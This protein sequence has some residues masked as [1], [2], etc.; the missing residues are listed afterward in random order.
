MYER[1]V[2]I[3]FF[4]LICISLVSAQKVSQNGI[5]IM[6]DKDVYFCEPIFKGDSC[7]IRAK[8]T[9]TNS[10]QNQY[11]IR[12]YT[13][14]S[15][16]DIKKTKFLLHRKQGIIQS[17]PKRK[18][19]III[20]KKRK[21][22]FLDDNSFDSVPLLQKDKFTMTVEFWANTSGKFN[23]SIDLYNPST[24]QFIGSVVL[25]PFYNVTT[26]ATTP[27]YQLIDGVA[28]NYS[29]DKFNQKIDITS[30][31]SDNNA[32]TK[33]FSQYAD[34]P[35]EKKY[36]VEGW[37]FNELEPQD[38]L[39]SFTGNNDGFIL[40]NVSSIV[41][42][43]YYGHALREDGAYLV[44]DRDWFTMTPH[45]TICIKF[46]Q[47]P[48]SSYNYFVDN[49]PT[50]QTGYAFYMTSTGIVRCYIENS[51]TSVS[52]QSS[53]SYD[54]GN[55]HIACCMQDGSN[56]SLWV[57]GSLVDTGGYVGFVNSST[58][59]FIGDSND[60]DGRFGGDF[61]Q[62]GF[63][64][65]S[66]NAS[67]IASFGNYSIAD[68]TKAITI[69]P[70]FNYTMTPSNAT[71]YLKIT[72]EVKDLSTIRVMAYK[73]MTD[74]NSSAYITSNIQSGV[75]YFKLNDIIYDGYNLPFRVWSLLA[76]TDVAI[77]EIQL[78]ETGDDNTSP[79]IHN[80]WLNT[81]NIS[82]GGSVRMA[83]NIT[84][85]I[86]IYKTFFT[87]NE[88]WNG[89][90][91]YEA[92]KN[93]DVWYVDLTYYDHYNETQTVTFYFVNTSDLAGNTANATLNLT[94]GYECIQSCVENWTANYSSCQINDSQFKTYYDA[95]NCGTFDNLPSD[96]GTWVACDY[97][98]ENIV[99]NET[100]CY[101][102]GGSYYKNVSY[103]D[104]NYASCCQV[105]NL[106]S[107]CSILFYP[108]NTTTVQ[109]CLFFN[110]TMT[111]DVNT[112]A[113]YGFFN[114]K[115]KWICYPQGNISQKCVSYVKDV[116][117]G[118]VQVNPEYKQ[119]PTTFVSFSS[120]ETEPRTFFVAENGLVTVYFTKDNLIF[121]GREYIFGVK[122]SDGNKTVI[123]EQLM[124]PEYE[125]I[126]KPIGW[127]LF[128]RNNASMVFPSFI[129][130]LLIFLGLAVVVLLFSIFIK[131]QLR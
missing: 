24:D 99:T 51:A 10:N 95:N 76:R 90:R 109:S 70:F 83:C 62:L 84:D 116:N 122:C 54:D 48:D 4:V 55:W 30:G 88:S 79:V 37:S 69:D 41:V 22:H 119:K 57:D 115:I 117:G 61:A 34:S 46:R 107:D 43:D 27:S 28:M 58:D 130:L 75:S 65:T 17:L 126:V 125:N 129:M 104:I 86:G 63:F 29:Q 14:F 92:N 53:S 110:N 124:T 23:Y 13:S 16:H 66:L 113:E 71:Y 52:L 74:V 45:Y 44:H 94:F 85:N 2:F 101:Y 1:G 64:N 89:T 123:Y 131:K 108:Y 111:C 49:H 21:Q 25:D 47:P 68:F 112:F 3:A 120:D 82:C 91:T 78:Y 81:S 118:V 98:H 18:Q 11:S 36:L 56:T 73:N 72:S 50:G 35:V 38:V 33:Y 39:Y 20:G 77:S 7:L 96:N 59:L 9:V 97:C 103:I 32:S 106:T 6:S 5:T 67:T 80:C 87:V 128:L 102:S 8:I 100:D 26:N 127:S 31:L 42:G 40:G 19:K 93:G 12:G 60:L 105:T 114:D 121:D 15:K